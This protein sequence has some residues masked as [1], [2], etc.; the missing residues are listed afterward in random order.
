MSTSLVV[1]ISIVLFIGLSMQYAYRYRGNT[2]YEDFGEYIR[3]GW[4]IFTP[5]NCLL[6]IFTQKRAAKPVMNMADFPELKE[7]Q[8]NWQVIA[9]EARALFDNKAFDQ[10]TKE[11]AASYYD[12]GFRTFYKYGWSKFYLSWYGNYTHASAKRLCPKT[13]EILS[14]CKSVNGAMFSLL[15]PGS[16]LTRHLDPA[17]TS[18]RYHLGLAT[19]NSDDAFIN[20]D[21]HDLSWRDGEA[22]MFDETY[23]HYAKNNTSEHR[24]ILMCDIERPM[25]WPGKIFNALVYKPLMSATLVPNTD[26]DKRGFANKMFSSVV[27][28]LAKGKQLKQDNPPL[29]KIVKYSINT[30]L[31]AVILSLVAGII[32]L[33]LWLLGIV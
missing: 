10:I 29:Y 22:L 8:D 24:L 2:R 13:T 14:R 4:P 28:L 18:L 23:L 11:G 3:K 21:G 7:I 25:A 15:P 33:P 16:Q 32:Y 26:E 30:V 1:V 9:E 12:V 17:A 27:P 6:Y 5:F 31:L 19:P 20:V